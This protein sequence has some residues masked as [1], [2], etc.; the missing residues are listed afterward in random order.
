MTPPLA[1]PEETPVR[2]RQAPL[3]FFT[4]AEQAC[5]AA[6]LGLLTGQGDDLRIPLLEMVDARLA[7]GETDDWRYEDMPED[8][9]AWR[10]TLGHLDADAGT[11]CGTTF[12]AAPEEEQKAIL[13]SVLHGAD[14]HGL[15]AA[16]VWDLWTRYARTALYSHPYAWD[17]TDLPGPAYLAGAG[18]L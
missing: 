10:D 18:G 11:R 15:H 16:R 9:Q 14:W 17:Q 12:A 1:D 3:R 8:G 4:D 2:T 7:A 5:A 6:I 13:Q